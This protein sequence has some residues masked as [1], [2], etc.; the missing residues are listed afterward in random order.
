[1]S[2]SER[3][4][5]VE[6]GIIP[7]IA[8]LDHLCKEPVHDL[9][10]RLQQQSTYPSHTLASAFNEPGIGYGSASRREMVRRWLQHAELS[11][12][13]REFDARLQMVL[14]ELRRWEQD[15]RESLAYLADDCAERELH[16]LPVEAIHRFGESVR[17]RHDEIVDTA[18][19]ASD[20]LRQL[21][22]MLDRRGVQELG[23][24]E[25]LAFEALAEQNATS[26]ARRI[27]AEKLAKVADVSAN[28]NWKAAC[29][30]LA[31]RGYARATSGRGSGYWLVAQGRRA[32][33]MMTGKT[34]M[35]D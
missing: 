28:A 17:E 25:W 12:D 35:T 11:E 32:Y 15:A 30:S 6:E 10:I 16:G 19:S 27:S 3:W 34:V 1:M 7:I 24:M 33:E 8:A 29:A 14:D 22:A 31:K 20:Y 2:L 9:H 13:A 18:A 21:V 4:H 26:E 23:A 5:P